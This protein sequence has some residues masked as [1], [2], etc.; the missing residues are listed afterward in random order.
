VE[1]RSS[2]RPQA[3]V[4]PPFTALGSFLDSTSS[5][6]AISLCRPG[7]GPDSAI[8]GGTI[9]NITVHPHRRIEVIVGVDY[10]ADQDQTRTALK[11][12]TAVYAAQTI[13][14]ESR[15]SSTRSISGFLS[16]NST[17]I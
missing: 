12:A 6:L 7:S 16:R 2:N 15:G 9:E 14:G 17:C 11:A 4:V 1:S 3:R 10:T 13:P 5:R 8:S